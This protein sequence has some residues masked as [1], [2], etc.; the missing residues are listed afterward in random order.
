MTFDADFR[1]F[2]VSLVVDDGYTTGQAAAYMWGTVSEVTVRRWVHDYR[3]EGRLCAL[4][5]R[6]VHHVDRTLTPNVA[7]LLA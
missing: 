4:R 6:G 1:A 7:V 5:N 3:V 2:A